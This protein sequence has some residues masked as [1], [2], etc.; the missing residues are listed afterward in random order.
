[1]TTSCIRASVGAEVVCEQEEGME[2]GSWTGVSRRRVMHRCEQEGGMEEGHGQPQGVH[3]GSETNL[4][5]MV[6]ENRQR[7]EGWPGAR[8]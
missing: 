4:D 8:T 7:P 3:S 1:M 6:P 2:G 5:T